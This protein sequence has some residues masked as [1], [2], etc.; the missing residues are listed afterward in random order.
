MKEA[1]LEKE[2][3]LLGKEK[4]LHKKEKE[5]HAKKKVRHEKKNE[6]LHEKG[7]ILEFKD[8]VF[9][10]K[11]HILELKEQQVLKEQQPNLQMSFQ[12]L[13]YS[14]CKS[15]FPA[16]YSIIPFSHMS[17]ILSM[18]LR[19]RLVRSSSSRERM[20]TRI[21]SK[22]KR[23]RRRRI[24]RRRRLKRRIFMS[25]RV[26]F[27]EM[28]QLLGE[29]KDTEGM[30][31]AQDKM[32]TE[33]MEKEAAVKEDLKKSFKLGHSLVEQR[34]ALEEE[35]GKLMTNE[36]LRKKIEEEKATK[37]ISK[38]QESDLIKEVPLIVQ[39]HGSEEVKQVD[40][41]LF[42][43]SD[44]MMAKITKGGQSEYP[45]RLPKDVKPDHFEDIC[46]YQSYH[47]AQGRSEKER[48]EF[49]KNFFK[50]KDK[51]QI[52]ALGLAAVSLGLQS[53]LKS[54]RYKLDLEMRSASQDDIDL[55][56]GDPDK[57]KLV[58]PPKEKTGIQARMD[59]QLKRKETSSSNPT[60]TSGR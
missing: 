24:K 19:R 3:E 51:V 26:L 11:D 54:A 17:R 42:Q 13:L 39:L 8:H 31:S 14:L 20:S 4:E 32:V 57:A 48:K 58:M 6:I 33:A 43:S 5:L 22:R 2:K 16:E 56:F 50:G 30:A 12:L 52:A 41:S 49:N 55:L 38:N 37:A 28:E 1:I 10:M 53:M 18:R 15:L 60:S 34:K 27:N 59:K 35:I 9:Q 44:F 21:L 46:H 7:Q 36:K 25:R 40:R 23:R 45:I 47:E 29:D